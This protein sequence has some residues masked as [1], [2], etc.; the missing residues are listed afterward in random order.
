MALPPPHRGLVIPAGQLEDPN[1]S[2]TVMPPAP[3]ALSHLS[4]QEP[5][6]FRLI[7]S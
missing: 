1:I 6:A 5:P 3:E 7:P 4:F 2:D